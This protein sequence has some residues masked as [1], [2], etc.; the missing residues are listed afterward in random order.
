MA[1]KKNAKKQPQ[2]NIAE[3]KKVDETPKSA[4]AVARLDFRFGDTVYKKGEAVELGASVI[5]HLKE[6]GF[7]E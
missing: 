6:R 7:V 4:K 1:E 5:K 2:K 3:T